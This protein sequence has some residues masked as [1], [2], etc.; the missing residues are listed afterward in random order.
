MDRCEVKSLSDY[1]LSAMETR[2]ISLIYNGYSNK[3]IAQHLCIAENTVKHHI[4]SIYSKFK[5]KNRIG[6]IQSIRTNRIII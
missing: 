3:K 1:D 6:L 2:I 5:V 4:T